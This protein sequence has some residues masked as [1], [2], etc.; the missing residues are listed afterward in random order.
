MDQVACGMAGA[1]VI[2]AVSSCADI[3]R[4]FFDACGVPAWSSNAANAHAQFTVCMQPAGQFSQG[5]VVSF[6]QTTLYVSS[7]SGIDL[8]WAAPAASCRVPAPLV[9]RKSRSNFSKN[10]RLPPKNALRLPV[11]PRRARRPIRFYVADCY[12]DCGSL[13]QRALS[14]QRELFYFDESGLVPIH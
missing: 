13:H 5:Q 10:D 8:R 12:E 4:V 14:G 6:V 2:H 11:T 1:P 7:A 9:R 3:N